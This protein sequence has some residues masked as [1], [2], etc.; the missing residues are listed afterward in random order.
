LM[1]FRSVKL[2]DI[3]LNHFDSLGGKAGL[4]VHQQQ[5]DLYTG[6][7]AHPQRSGLVKRYMSR[8]FFEMDKAYMRGASFG[9]RI[10]AGFVFQA[11]DFDLRL[12]GALIAERL[13]PVMLNLRNLGRFYA[14]VLRYNVPMMARAAS[15][16]LSALVM[17][18]PITKMLA[19]S[20]RASRG[21]T[22]RF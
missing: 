8:A 4:G 22:V 15:S 10:D 16:G 21:V 3:R 1:R 19:P 11:T 12:H 17:G 9:R 13:V 2:H 5:D 18:R 6:G 14:R 20:S 7:R